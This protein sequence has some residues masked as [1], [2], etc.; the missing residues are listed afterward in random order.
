MTA[1][2]ILRAAGIGSYIMFF[3]SV[4]W[5][6]VATT[7]PF[8]KRIAK[9]SATLIHQFLSTCGLVLLG[10]HLGGLLLDRF[11]VFSVADLLVPMRSTYRPVATAA[12]ILAMYG[13]VFVIVTSWLR[14][15]LGA[16]R[17]RRTHLLAVPI[18]TLALLHGI[19]AGTDTARPVM[20]WMY[21]A[22][23]LVVLF[24]IVVRGLTVGW[25]PERRPIPEHVERTRAV[26][27]EGREPSEVPHRLPAAVPSSVG[28][29]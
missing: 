6:L 12:G 16:A 26:A 7:S 9:P 8:G 19:L 28:E 22:T 29:A 2:N 4:T 5:G 14:R 27:N 17:W 23:G 1:W 21:V 18:F 3:L 25:R 13:T 20:W 10:I 24:L 11:I 15:P